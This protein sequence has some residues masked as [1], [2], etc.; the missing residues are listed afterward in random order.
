MAIVVKWVTLF[1]FIIVCICSF[2]IYAND[3]MSNTT[4]LT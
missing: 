3:Y 2:K 4:I 1:C